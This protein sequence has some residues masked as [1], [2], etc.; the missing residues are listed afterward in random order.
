MF[1]SSGDLLL[2]TSRGLARQEYEKE[3][4]ETKIKGVG[5]LRQT[6]LPAPPNTLH[7]IP[8]LCVKVT[9]A[10]VCSPVNT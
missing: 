4:G 3:E 7:A 1:W 6:P 8:L 9:V 10:K 2:S 5:R